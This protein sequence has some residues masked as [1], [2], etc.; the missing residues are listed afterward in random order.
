M[1]TM[2]RLY[3]LISAA[4]LLFDLVFLVVKSHRL[5]HFRP[6]DTAFERQLRAELA[7]H[8]EHGTFSPNFESRLPALLQ[9]TQNLIALQKELEQQPDAEPWLRGAVYDRLDT[10]LKKNERERS[11]YA[12]LISTLDYSVEPVP[13]EFAAKFLTLLDSHTLSTFSNAMNAIYRFGEV[14]LL[15]TALDTVSAR[16]RFYH[17]KL[18][19]DGLLGAT[20]DRAVLYP[21][22]M[23]RFPDYSPY[24]Q[25][26]LIDLFRMSGFDAASFC[27]GLLRDNETA[28]QVRYTVMRYFAQHPTEESKL[29]FMSVLVDAD[30]SW[31]GQMLAIQGLHPYEEDAVFRAVSEK[32]SSKHWH[33]RRCAAAYIRLHHPA[34]ERLAEL[35]RTQDRYAGDALLY[36]YRDDPDTAHFLQETVRTLGATE[37]RPAPVE[38]VSV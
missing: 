33:I 23:E 16:D 18:L 19:V 5:R 27:E 1:N 36:Q 3:I 37:E 25:E 38:K 30:A 10:Y 11:F 17:K 35:L 6:R 32:L 12:Y 21:A 24:V 26:G 22:L 29:Y 20:A 2:I 14:H 34:R 31:V 7:H 13:P 8:R 9:K 15:C 28:E 4:L